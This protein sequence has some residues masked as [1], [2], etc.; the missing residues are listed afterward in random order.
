MAK[1]SLLERELK[2]AKLIR[3]HYEKRQAL[4]KIVSDINVSDEE[5]QAAM[6]KLNKLPRNSSPIRSRNRCQFTGRS[7]GYLRKFKLSRLCFRE[8]SHQ[9]LVPGIFKASW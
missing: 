9:G 2:R 1:K 8:M 7:R 3:K 6:I 4:K 5:R